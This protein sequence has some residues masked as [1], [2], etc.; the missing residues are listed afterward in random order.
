MS[1]RE[2]VV[3][4]MREVLADKG[5]ERAEFPDGASLFDD[6]G[7]DSLDM[8][9]IVARLDEAVGI[10]PFATGAPRFATVGEFVALYEGP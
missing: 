7:L 9:T 8:A 10:D 2:V 1:R 6:V 4:I 3:R 5:V